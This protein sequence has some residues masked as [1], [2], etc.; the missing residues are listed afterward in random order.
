MFLSKVDSILQQQI[1]MRRHNNSCLIAASRANILAK[2]GVVSSVG[3]KYIR[4]PH[5]SK[6][7]APRAANQTGTGSEAT[8]AMLAI[9]DPAPAWRTPGGVRSTSWSFVRSSSNIGPQVLFRCFQLIPILIILGNPRSD[10]L[11]TPDLHSQM[12]YLLGSSHVI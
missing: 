3:K 5:R 4:T 12:I 1:L 11:R 10:P 2:P 7:S 9:P 6:R 8:S